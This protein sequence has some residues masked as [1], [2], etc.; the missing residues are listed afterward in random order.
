[1]SPFRDQIF[2]ET[3]QRWWLIWFVL[4][5]QLLTID[6]SKR[7]EQKSC[8]SSRFIEEN[9]I[10]TVDVASS[11]AYGDMTLSQNDKK[12]QKLYEFNFL[13]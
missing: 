3:E 11:T 6:I 12:T 4:T 13:S 5:R 7:D 1:M 2:V 8:I 9:T 10:D